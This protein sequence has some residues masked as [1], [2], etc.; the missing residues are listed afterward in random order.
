MTYDYVYVY[1]PPWDCIPGPM[2]G[3]GPPGGAPIALHWSLLSDVGMRVCRQCDPHVYVERVSC[4]LCHNHSREQSFMSLTSEIMALVRD[5][6]DT[7]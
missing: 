3:S 1:E 4:T 7:N 6:T 2:S 5:V